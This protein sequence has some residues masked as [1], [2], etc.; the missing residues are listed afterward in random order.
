[1][2]IPWSPV[3]LTSMWLEIDRAAPIQCA[4]RTELNHALRLDDDQR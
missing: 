1:M 2:P 4:Q 3:P